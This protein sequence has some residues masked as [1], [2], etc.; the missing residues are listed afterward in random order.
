MKKTV[1]I[2]GTSR[3]IGLSLANIFLKNNYR[4]IG[5]SRVADDNKINH[6]DFELLNLDLASFGSM[7]IFEKVFAEKGIKLDI[8]VNNAAVGPDLDLKL[9][10]EVSFNQTLDI[11]LTGTVFFTELMLNH[12]A[13]GGK[14]V[15][16]SSK[17]GSIG[18]C[19]SPDSP[20]YRISKA[21]LNMYTKILVNRY[22]GKYSIAAL[23]PG[24]VRTTLAKSNVNGRLSPDESAARI[25]E[26]ISS[27]FKT[28]IFWNVE[29]KEECEW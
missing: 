13:V 6:T 2:T 1:L 19:G 23:H 5:T 21:A 7:N 9:P 29:T 12:L 24:W 11:N 16:I 20:A 26:F 28:G 18:L 4:V 8:L 14:I 17:M 25:Y 3:G 22:A 10:E 27:G 15:N